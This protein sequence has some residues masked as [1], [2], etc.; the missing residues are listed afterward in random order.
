MNN[1]FRITELKIFLLIVLSGGF[2]YFFIFFKMWTRGLRLHGGNE[3]SGDNN[4]DPFPWIPLDPVCIFLE[5]KWKKGSWKRFPFLSFPGIFSIFRIFSHHSRVDGIPYP[6]KIVNF[7][8]IKRIKKKKK[9]KNNKYRLISHESN[10]FHA[11]VIL[12][13]LTQQMRN[14]RA[15]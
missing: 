14:Y 3:S 9:K 5:M 11:P 1:A 7:N 2:F 6:P 8:I 15:N 4:L 13:N 12:T 10:N